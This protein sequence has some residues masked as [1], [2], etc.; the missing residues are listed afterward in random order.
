MGNRRREGQVLG[1]LGEIL[2]HRGHSSTEGAQQASDQHMSRAHQ[3]LSEGDSA[4]L[5]VLHCRQ[6]RVALARAD[7]T[8]ARASL[9]QAEAVAG[10]VSPARR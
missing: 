6:A 2:A 7:P 1:Q 3:L 10:R 5:G 8:A 9:E 4:E